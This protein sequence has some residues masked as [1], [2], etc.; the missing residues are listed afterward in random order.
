MEK[1]IE[2]QNKR[3]REELLLNVSYSNF[4]DIIKVTYS[5]NDS[6]LS[7]DVLT[8]IINQIEK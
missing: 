4:T 3:F 6:Q 7:Y 5:S 2:K 8:E 1:E